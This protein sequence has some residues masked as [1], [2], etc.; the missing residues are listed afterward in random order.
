ML[1]NGRQG[2]LYILIISSLPPH[3]ITTS[4]THASFE[5]EDH[6]PGPYLTLLLVRYL[7]RYRFYILTHMQ[8]TRTCTH[9]HKNTLFPRFRV[10]DGIG[11]GCNSKLLILTG[12]SAGPDIRGQSN[13]RKTD[14][15]TS[16][17]R[18]SVE[19]EK[20]SNQYSLM[21]IIEVIRPHEQWT[22]GQH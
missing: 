13:Q 14:M 9:T 10:A 17:D 8:T 20:K 6:L 15:N 11:C 7:C 2:Q 1:T 12:P 5:G 21:N 3:H 18:G 22:F 4:S 16:A 19:Q